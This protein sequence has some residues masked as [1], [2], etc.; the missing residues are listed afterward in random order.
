[1]RVSLPGVVVGVAVAG[2]SSESIPFVSRWPFDRLVT[3]ASSS[4]M[5][6]LSEEG[7]RGCEREGE[8]G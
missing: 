8:R 1:M 7:E 3:C 5:R 4:D 6:T 2:L